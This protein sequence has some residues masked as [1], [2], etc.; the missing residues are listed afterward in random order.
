MAA[1]AR[2]SHSGTTR[3]SSLAERVKDLGAVIEDPDLLKVRRSE[4]AEAATQLFRAKGYGS[5]SISEIAQ[6]AG[7]SVG[8]VYL[9]IKSK[10][11]LLLLIFSDVVELYEKRIFQIRDMRGTATERL[12]T[13]I[14]EYYTVLDQHHA[15]TEVMYHEFGH[16]D[17]STREYVSAVE[18]DL[19]AVVRSIVEQGISAREFRQVNTDLMAQMILWNGHMWALNRGRVRNR[20]SL[21]EFIAQQTEVFDRLLEHTPSP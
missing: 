2:V 14:L 11:D 3:S 13:A 1:R 21:E 20:M 16:L 17:P 7:V 19:V 5:T 4:L 6:A 8:A 12:H 18:D 9:Y 15:R 10:P